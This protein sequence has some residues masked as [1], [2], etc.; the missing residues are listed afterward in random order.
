M[1][2]HTYKILYDSSKNIER[3][4]RQPF[5]Q[6]KNKYSIYFHLFI[7]LFFTHSLSL[8]LSMFSNSF[9]PNKNDNIYKEKHMISN[10]QA[11]IEN[12]NWLYMKYNRLL[13]QDYRVGTLSMFLLTIQRINMSSLKSIGKF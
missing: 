1:K 6:I 11:N 7:S 4:A 5:N 8:S 2:G 12:K 13:G 3:V 9:K 10:R